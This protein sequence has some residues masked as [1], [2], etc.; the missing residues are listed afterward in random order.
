MSRKYVWIES[1][2]DKIPLP[3]PVLSLIVAAVI[4]LI[5]E[6]FS[7]K[8]D[9]F[10]LYDITYV[11]PVSAISILIAYQLAGIQYLLN[12]MRKTFKGLC[13][14][15]GSDLGMARLKERFD[16]SRL[17]YTTVIPVVAVFVAID[18]LRLNCYQLGS[19]DL[20]SCA[21]N[22]SGTCGNYTLFTPPCLFT[23]P[24]LLL[25]SWSFGFDIFR[26]LI[27]YL[28]YYLLGI[29]IWIILIASLLLGDLIGYVQQNR[30]EMDIFHVD[31]MGGLKPILDFILKVSIF[32]F[33]GV[34][35]IITS[36]LSPLNPVPLEVIFLVILLFIG[37]G[38]FFWGKTAIQI[39][40]S[41]RIQLELTEINHEFEKQNKKL[42]DLISHDMDDEAQKE[43]VFLSD[44]IEILNKE[45]DRL[46]EIKTSVIDISTLIPFIS[47]F[48]TTLF[49]ILEKYK[50]LRSL[51][52]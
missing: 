45:R 19:Y 28:G 17:C 2:F 34:A 29:I 44:S 46:L 10:N 24:P 15:S 41:D 47:S 1:L 6:F 48:I 4:C 33:I 13:L 25:R 39:I 31:K 36:N 35:L 27:S 16:D 37:V 43:M 5:F 8:V 49:A 30:I 52:R 51:F 40:F 7:T 14:R 12:D 20:N 22:L 42:K 32:Y 26:Y 23:N 11:I 3:Y 18:I 9:L 21:Y 50:E 38:F